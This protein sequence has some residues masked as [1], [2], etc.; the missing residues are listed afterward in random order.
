[1]PVVERFNLTPV[2]STALIHPDAIDLRRESAVA[3]RR[4]LFVHA[5]GERL[6]GLS[7]APLFKI[8]SAYD[9]DREYLRLSFPE[10]GFDFEGDSTSFGE[11]AISTSRRCTRSASPEPRSSAAASAS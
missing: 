8:R 9:A 3:D 4:F 2:K 10:H 7:K 6:S 5:N 11:L 1:M